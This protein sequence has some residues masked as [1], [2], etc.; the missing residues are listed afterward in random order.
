MSTRSAAER[1]P[2]PDFEPLEARSLL[3]IAY[4][5]S[6]EVSSLPGFDPN[7]GNDMT[8]AGS[9]ENGEYLWSL[10]MA[11][12]DNPGDAARFIVVR[13]E[14]RHIGDIPALAGVRVLDINSEGAAVGEE[15]DGTA[16]LYDIEAG[17]E[18]VPIESLITDAPPDFNAAAY[19][20]LAISDAGAI[21]FA[22]RSHK[23]EGAVWIL[24]DGRV[25]QLWT[26]EPG[27]AHFVDINS[28]NQVIGYRTAGGEDHQA[29]LW[30]PGHGVRTLGLDRVF[31]LNDAAQVLAEDDEAVVLWQSGEQ[32]S[33]G[34]A[35][36]SFQEFTPIG[37]DGAGRA[38]VLSTETFQTVYHKLMVIDDA[39]TEIHERILTGGTSTSFDTD[40]TESGRM[41]GDS[42]ILDPLSRAELM[43]AI[44]GDEVVVIRDRDRTL[45]ALYGGH[46][47]PMA[48]ERSGPE[49]RWDLDPQSDRDETRERGLVAA[50][51]DPG[52]G[53]LRIVVQAGGDG[54]QVLRWSDDTGGLFSTNE[55][56]LRRFYMRRAFTAFLASDGRAHIAGLGDD[57]S[58]YLGFQTGRADP[59]WGS[60]S[61]TRHLLARGIRTPRFAGA[62]AGFA[63]PWGAMNIAGLDEAGRVQSV[64]WSPARR[65]LG[66]M[67]SDITAAAG[68]P[69]LVGNLAASATPWGAM[70]IFGTDARGHAIAIW[71]TRQTGWQSTDLTTL[72]AGTPLEAGTLSSAATPWGAIELVGR[73]AA[74]EVAAYWWAPGSGGWTFES[75]TSELAPGTPRIVG[76]ASISI[77]PDGSQ[78]ISGISAE[79]AVIHLY[80]LLDGQDLWRAE[81]LTEL[82]LG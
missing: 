3:S 15:A 39:A 63:S 40:V 37:L 53:G 41:V 75:I 14:V 31:A 56:G 69:M 18:R 6:I 8:I 68:A 33:L 27:L 76:P 11:R 82:A 10:G 64:W 23:V 5:A 42:I 36:S 59:D 17:G 24:I 81:N 45:A 38:L 80:W 12:G 43:A 47:A 19:D 78:H 51:I 60:A 20:P 9:S 55:G 50:Y 62:L 30:A 77:G 2:A 13:D 54:A 28:R 74:D 21:V 71:W 73:T 34:L 48:F 1:P 52:D 35:E 46:G 66:W 25:R 49:V 44:P 79:G 72:T 22:T 4:Y 29:V 61:L 16:F 67:V 26:H 65:G 58:L 70:Q 7:D 32:R 57:G